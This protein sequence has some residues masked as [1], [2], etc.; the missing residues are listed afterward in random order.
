MNA[1]EFHKTYQ[2]IDFEKWIKEGLAYFNTKE[3]KKVKNYMLKNT[4][5]FILS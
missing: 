1:L 4:V 2:S 3:Q 5:E